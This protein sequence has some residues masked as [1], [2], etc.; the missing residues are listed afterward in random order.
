MVASAT[1]QRPGAPGVSARFPD[2]HVTRRGGVPDAKALDADAK[3]ALRSFYVPHNAELEV[4]LGRRL[5]EWA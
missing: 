4:M 1:R 5:V 3:A 2:E